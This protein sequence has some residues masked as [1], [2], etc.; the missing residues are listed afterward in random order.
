MA[1]NLLREYTNPTSTFVHTFSHDLKSLIY[2]FIW[3]C[4]LYQ[5]PNKIC[6][7]KTAEQTCLKHW[8]LAKMVNNIQALHAQKLGQ[9]LSKIVLDHF[10]LYFAPMKPFITQLYKLIQ[11]SHDSNSNISLT[12][13]A[14]VD[15][16]MNAFN[17]IEKVSCNATNV[18]WAWQS[19]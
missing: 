15:M 4:V 7:D 17:S 10:I 1:I 2:T 18:K 16:F 5:A 19:L 13:T 6:H 11:F 12:H 9:L 14:I 8:V 3:V